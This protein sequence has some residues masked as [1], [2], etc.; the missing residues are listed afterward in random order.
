MRKN[1]LFTKQLKKRFVSI[2]DSI[3]SSFNKLNLFIL[4]LKKFKLSRDNK[5]FL[6]IGI[7]V[8]SLISYFQIPN[9]YSKELIQSEIENQISKKY[10]IDL[11]IKKK[12]KFGLFP[13]PHFQASNS[14][15]LSNNNNIADIS[16]LK[17]FISNSNFF[18]FNQIEVKDLI[19]KG[20]NFEITKND[21]SFFFNLLKN[22]P[23]ENEI[24]IKDSN[25]F[26]KENDELLF[27]NKIEKY[28]FFYD[29]KNLMNVLTSNNEIFNVPFKL[30]L[31]NDKF[32]KK[33]FVDFKSKKFRLTINNVTNL[34]EEIKNGVLDILLLNKGTSLDYK[35]GKNSLI[36]SSND[37]QNKFE[38]KIDFK[39]FYFKADFNYEG[40]SSKNILSDKSIIYDLIK[41]EIFNNSNLNVNVN[42]DV[43]DIVNID[44]LNDLKLRL[45]IEEGDIQLS[46]SSIHWK[47]DLLIVLNESLINYNEEDINLIGKVLIKIKDID[48]FYTSFQVKKNLRKKIKEIQF[49]INY[50]LIT[51]D[52][53][54]DNIKIDK[55][56]N[57]EVEK[58]INRFNSKTKR[59]F[60]KI[61]FKNFINNFFLAYSG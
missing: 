42:L 14:S 32:N 10:N 54:F 31:K 7:I 40:L 28:K 46:N 39:P 51:H 36:Y 44:E 20:V 58:F 16:N 52:V 23:N 4:N 41:S 18:K 13:K 1:S 12:I 34:E 47:D 22:E 25:I 17:V 5:A 45:I 24:I 30:I 50:N 55:N 60:N 21:M 9:F 33:L 35:I 29:S 53:S 38:G 15:I 43:K 3:E 8:I 27:I 48:N 59:E 61:T 26:F 6:L 49:D 37:N 2:N 19:L 11:E 57:E 56:S